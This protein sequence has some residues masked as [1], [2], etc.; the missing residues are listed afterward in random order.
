MCS[1]FLSNFNVTCII[2]ADFLKTF[3]YCISR[4]YVQ[5]E[6]NC[7]TRTD[8]R[9]GGRTDWHDVANSRFSEF[10][11]R[12][13]RPYTTQKLHCQDVEFLNVKPGGP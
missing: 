6:P 9:M 12:A 4:K 1:L 13:W 11:E 5:W 2:S 10:Y 7:S 8:G 3:K